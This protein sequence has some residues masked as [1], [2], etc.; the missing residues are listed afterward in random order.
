MGIKEVRRMRKKSRVF[1]LLSLVLAGVLLLFVSGCESRPAADVK[2][3]IGVTLRRPEIM[4][5]VATER[6][7][8]EQIYTDQI[9]NVVVSADGT[10]FQE[11]LLNQIKQFTA[12]IKR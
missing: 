4:L 5:V 11:Y 10:T 1:W 7:R 6:N 3:E 9:W 12:D 8:Y 2:K